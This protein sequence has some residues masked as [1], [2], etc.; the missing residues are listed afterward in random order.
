[1]A[2]THRQTK[3]RRAMLALSSTEWREKSDGATRSRTEDQAQAFGSRIR[4]RVRRRHASNKHP[5]RS[6][7]RNYPGCFIEYIAA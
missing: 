3:F 7:R 6:R 4:D 1:M 2:R 5:K